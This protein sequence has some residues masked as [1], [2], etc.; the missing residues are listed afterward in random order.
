VLTG[1]GAGRI[2]AGIPVDVKRMDLVH[3]LTDGEMLFLRYARPS[4]IAE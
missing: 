2:V 3:A 1:P 4:N